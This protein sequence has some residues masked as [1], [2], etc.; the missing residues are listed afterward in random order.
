MCTCNNFNFI[1]IKYYK[2]EFSSMPVLKKR[3]GKTEKKLKFTYTTNIE[4]QYIK[5][6]LWEWRQ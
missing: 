4:H 2:D 6:M 5:T 3:Q 1:L